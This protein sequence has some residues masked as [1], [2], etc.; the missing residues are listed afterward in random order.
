MA[1]KK[2][3]P[4]QVSQKDVRASARKAAVRIGVKKI[5]V[6]QAISQRGRTHPM[7]AP[8]PGMPQTA[9]TVLVE[10]TTIKKFKYYI[11]TRILRVWF[12]NGGS[13]KYYEVP[14]SVVLL[15]AQAQSKGSFFYY[16]IRK[17]YRYK[18]VS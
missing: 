9:Q 16:N 15:F 11:R 8:L 13:Y 4:K 7:E 17:S 18:K 3:Q 1:A 10:S 12:V 6:K 2:K 14:Q 5:E